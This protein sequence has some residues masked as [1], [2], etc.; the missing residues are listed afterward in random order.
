MEASNTQTGKQ[1]GKLK[2][3]R[4][5]RYR[6]WTLLA[7]AVLAAIAVNRITAIMWQIRELPLQQPSERQLRELQVRQAGELLRPV[8]AILELGGHVTYDFEFDKD[9]EETACSAWL[10]DSREAD[11]LKHILRVQLPGDRVTDAA[12]ENVSEMTNIDMLQLDNT[13]VTD[14]GLKHLDGL[15]Q[16]ATLFLDNSRITDAG[17]VHLRGLSHLWELSLKG[18]QVTGAGLAELKGI[19]NGSYLRLSLE[20]CPLTDGALVSLEDLSILRE[21]EL[22][23]TPITDAALVH[24]KGLARLQRLYLGH[25]RITDAGLRHLEGLNQLD[26]LYL[27]DT[28]VTGVGL[29]HL[30]RLT[31]LGQLYLDGCPVTDAG[32]AQLDGADLS[33]LSLE[34]TQ[35]TD[36]ALRRAERLTRNAYLWLRVKDTKVTD[37]GIRELKKAHPHW[38]IMR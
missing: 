21:L 11:L 32:V 23:N 38:F 29:G 37:A 34:R 26:T 17:L 4:R 20:G 12:L 16:L 24:L 30:K 10:R 25:T 19:G 7:F 9:G 14:A 27:Q 6:L 18:T 13:R 33:I 2:P 15:K 1:S 3:R 36:A 5:V 31:K 35:V 8:K 28:D 22:N